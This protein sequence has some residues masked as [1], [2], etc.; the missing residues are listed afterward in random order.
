MVNTA[1]HGGLGIGNDA[2]DTELDKDRRG[3]LRSMSE[4]IIDTEDLEV[5]LNVT[6]G[7]IAENGIGAVDRYA[8]WEKVEEAVNKTRKAVRN[9]KRNPLESVTATESGNQN[10]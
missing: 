10:P 4:V 7:F 2:A 6:E 8:P 9:D 1:I 3:R 5:L